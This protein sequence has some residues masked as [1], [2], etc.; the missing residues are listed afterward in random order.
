MSLFCLTQSI[1]VVKVC[2]LFATT[3]TM[4]YSVLLSAAVFGFSHGSMY[5]SN[6]LT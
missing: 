2:I 3:S 1:S 4:H 6:I 5:M